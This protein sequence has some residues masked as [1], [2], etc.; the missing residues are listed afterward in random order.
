MNESI[1][2]IGGFQVMF[3]KIIYLNV[4]NI[5]NVCDMKSSNS[6]TLKVLYSFNGWTQI[7]QVP[8]FRQIS[9]PCQKNSENY[10]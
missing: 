3:V 6:W 4:S 9:Q 5:S 1:H 8:W 10:L 2:L 7:V